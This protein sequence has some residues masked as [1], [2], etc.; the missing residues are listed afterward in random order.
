YYRR[1]IIIYRIVYPARGGALP[2][3]RVEGGI[4]I[5]LTMPAATKK[6]AKRRVHTRGR[7]DCSVAIDGGRRTVGRRVGAHVKVA[8][9]GRIVNMQKVAEP[10]AP[11]ATKFTRKLPED[12]SLP[13]HKA[14]VSEL[15]MDEVAALGIRGIRKEFVNDLKSYV[16]SG[17][18]S[19]WECEKNYDKN[20]FEDIRLLDCTRVILRNTPDNEDYIHASYVKVDE[21]FMFICAQGPLKNTAQHFLIMIVQ[22]GSKVVLQLCQAV[23]DGREQC[24]E[25]IPLDGTECKDYGAVRVRVLEKPKHVVS[26]KKV[27]RTKLQITYAGVS[28]EVRFDFPQIYQLFTDYNYMREYVHK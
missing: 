16:P 23:E 22:E 27:V 24:A 15:W 21:D 2:S 7:A 12:K 10:R 9:G 14:S 19:A 17:P 1:V 25:Y 11:I 3:V 4:S 26:L 13:S 28:H 20:R 8:V 6:L 18:Q 5:V